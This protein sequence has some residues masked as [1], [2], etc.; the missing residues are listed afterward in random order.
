M[1]PGNDDAIRSCA[2][3]TQRGR[4]RDRGRKPAGRGAEEMGDRPGG[5]DEPAEARRAGAAAEEARA[6]T[7]RAAPSPEATPP[8]SQR[9]PGASRAGSRRGVEVRDDDLGQPRQG[10]PRPDR[11]GDDGLQ[12]RARGDE[13]RPRGRAEAAA[14]EGH[15]AGGEARRTRDDRGRRRLSTSTSESARRWSPSAARPSRSRRTTSSRPSPSGCSRRSRTTGRGASRRSKTSASSSSRS[16][17]R[18]SSS[19][20]LSASRARATSCSP[21]TSTRR[22][23][24]SACS[25]SA[26]GSPDVACL[27]AKHIA[28]AA[29]RYATRDEVPEAEVERRA[30]DPREAGGRASKPEKVRGKIV[31]GRLEKWFFEGDVLPTR[32]GSTN[33]PTRRPGARGGGARGARVRALRSV[34]VDACSRNPS[35]PCRCGRLR[36]AACS[37]SSRARL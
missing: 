3:V 15:G 28:L 33:R 17:A 5:A 35:L 24:R 31:E 8:R 6:R 1:I 9:P 27:L 2:L 29:P 16:S 20:A 11:R 37:S 22:R 14:R 23:T 4:R 21:P 13:R 25:S 7:P 34:R 26:R 32:S 36:S 19:P 10:A 18:T 30:R 12:A